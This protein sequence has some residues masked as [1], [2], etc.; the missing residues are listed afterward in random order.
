MAS[1]LVEFSNS[2][3]DAV[4][5]VGT[6]VIAVLE[7]GREGVSGTLWSNGLAVTAEH[8]IR[9]YD[10]VNVVLPSGEK[11]KA[12]VAGR[13]PGTDIAVLKLALTTE[14]A[15]LADDS[16][17]RVGEVVLSVGRRGTDGLATTYGII[18][19]I[20]G[21]WRTWQGAR[22][23]RRFRLDLN[24]FTGFSGGPIVNA[25]GEVI[26]IATSGPRRSV[27]TIPAS[28]VTK[29]V[30]QLQKRGHIGR[31]YLGV[32]VQPVAFPDATY[33]AL[34]LASDRGL[35]IVTVAAGSSA[36]KSGILLGDIIVTI[37]GSPVRSARSLQPALDPENIGKSIE[38][39]VFRAAKL[40]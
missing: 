25:R 29:V 7:G 31:G 14:S 9:G 21:P 32:G 2:L 34:G 1:S 15:S 24:P 8:T 13:D 36:E 30:D 26:G 17:S 22:F 40:V 20:G 18:S 38:L 28:T 6:S 19:S 37:D 11:T 10:E 3:A 5:R 33:Q 39:E 16:Q 12:A 27:V 4:E 23:D 35:L